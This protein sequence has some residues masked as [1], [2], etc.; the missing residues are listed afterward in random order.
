[1]IDLIEENEMTDYSNAETLVLHGG[2]YRS[3]P[4]TNSVAVPIYQTTSFQFNNTDHAADLFALKTIF[5]RE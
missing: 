3:D 2:Q 1:M 4:S 5:I